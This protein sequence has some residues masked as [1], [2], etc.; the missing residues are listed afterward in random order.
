[1]KS[2]PSSGDSPANKKKPS[3]PNTLLSRMDR[4]DKTILLTL[5]RDK[6][7]LEE[8]HKVDR[9]R[10]NRIQK[11]FL[12][13]PAKIRALIAANKIGKTTVGVIDLLRFA[14]QGG[15]VCRV[16]SGLGFEKGIRDVIL[17][18]L[19]KWIPASRLIREKP[20]SQ[21]ITVKMY[22]RGDNG[23]ESV[24]S[25]MSAEQDDLVFEGDIVDYV[26]ID[27]PVRQ[28]IY[29]AS[30]RGLIITNGRLI[31]TL[32]PLEEPWIYNEIYCNP[33][34]EIEC[35]QGSLF[36]ALVENGGH[37][38]HEQINSFLSKLPEDEKPARVYGEF[39]HLVGRVYKAFDPKIHVIDP[40]RIPP[41]WPVWC[42]IDPHLR[43]PHAA[44]WLAVSP[45]ETWYICN[46]AY[47]KAGIED[48]GKEVLE[49]NRQYNMANT[50][51]DTSS[52]TADWNRRE[53]ARTL[54]RKIGLDTKLARKNNLKEASRLIIM[55]ALEGKDGTGVP[56]IYVFK[57]CKRT[58]FEFLNYV[59]DD[60]RAPESQGIKEAPKKINDEM[61]DNLGYIVVEPLRYHRPRL[62]HY[63][64]DPQH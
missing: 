38:T 59:W 51:I 8:E 6:A 46:E 12:E 19:K 4:T 27:E 1:M 16:I 34:P 7:R 11:K 28:S 10:P 15:K 30:L 18:E 52:E 20:N 61:L 57:N 40:F 13:S 29:I 25:F 53:T 43:K 63:A 41:D 17:S 23:Q 49:I 48:F 60:H 5:L 3:S 45:E 44:L 42:S 37:L 2:P 9:F 36:D 33:D 14:F 31:M 54:L 55:Q 24:I 26:W 56:K 47:F 35:F 39:R 32:T 21:G 58:Q 22:V 64:G 62:I 50:L